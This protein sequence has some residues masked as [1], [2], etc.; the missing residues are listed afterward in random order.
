MIPNLKFKMPALNVKFSAGLVGLVLGVLV[1]MIIG[2]LIKK[3]RARDH[4]V[5]KIY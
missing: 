2:V 1:G 4:D 3:G 5:S